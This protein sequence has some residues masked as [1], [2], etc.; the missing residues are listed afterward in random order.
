MPPPPIAVVHLDESCLGNGQDR[1]ALG[2]AAGLIE[3]RAG[4]DL[5][6]REVFIS[7]P[8][9]TN[10]RMALSGAIAVLQLLARKQRR[11]RTLMVSDSEY[12]VRGM[13]EW[14][15]G[16]IARGWKRS[17]GA[18]E[19]LELWQALVASAAEHEVQFTWV[20]GHRG[21]PKNEYADY[22]AVK[23]AREQI[24]SAGA[25]DSGF[26]TWLEGQRAAG[27]Y[28]DYDPEA[29]FVVLERRLA[30]GERF[31]LDAGA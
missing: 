13:R 31:P 24:T 12:L 8:D 22:L 23:A 20:R 16:W 6:R 15:S 2:G 3:A 27:R 7:S 29:A 11:I 19:N 14:V 1:P 9:T 25:V 17:A 18:V 30:A 10:N 28:L 26:D 4:A 5:V 21:H